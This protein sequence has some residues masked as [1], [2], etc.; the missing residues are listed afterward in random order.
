M[1]S[2]HRALP[3]RPWFSVSVVAHTHRA[4]CLCR[5]PHPQVH[6]FGLDTLTHTATTAAF[7]SPP[8]AL[9]FLPTEPTLVVV[10]AN[11]QVTAVDAET[12]HPTAW[13]RTHAGVLPKQWL[14]RREK[15]I[16]VSFDSETSPSTAYLH[17]HSGFTVVDFS[18]PIPGPKDHLHEIGTT[19]AATFKEE[20]RD[21]PQP[22]KKGDLAANT[23]TAGTNGTAGDGVDG[24][25]AKRLRATDAPTP[26]TQAPT[27]DNFKIVKKFQPLLF[28][29]CSTAGAVVVVERPW[30]AV[31][32]NLPPPLYRAKYGAV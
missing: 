17:D 11:N 1:A 14:S 12:G 20:R 16:G 22:H 32:K 10:C 4:A 3:H 21:K 8:S 7:T 5:P 29:G 24:R 2:E 18:R 31:L 23:A 9:A 26:S 27:E 15:V 28:M 19:I 30:L 6:L 13:S 25:A